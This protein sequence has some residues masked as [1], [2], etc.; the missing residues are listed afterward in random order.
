MPGISIE[1]VDLVHRRHVDYTFCPNAGITSFPADGRRVAVRMT[2]LSSSLPVGDEGIIFVLVNNP[3][4][5][6]T[7]CGIAYVNNNCPQVT[8]D[9]YTHGDMVINQYSVRC[10]GAQDVLI[11]NIIRG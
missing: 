8:I 2:L 10:V 9:L 4:G 1:H 3:S 7:P 6:Q 5:T 11:A